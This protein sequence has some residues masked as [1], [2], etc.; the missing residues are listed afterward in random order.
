M[1]D[2]QDFAE[3]ELS[4]LRFLRRKS[5][6]QSNQPATYMRT[7]LFLGLSA[8]L[9]PS[10]SQAQPFDI[11]T[12]DPASTGPWSEVGRTTLTVPKVPNGSIALDGA[13]SSQEY[14]GFN[15]ITVTPGVN[16]W[17][18][19]FPGDR[20]W[21]SPD[22]SSFTYWLAHDD[23]NF[24]VGVQVKDD[25][26]TSDDPNGSFWKDDAIEIVVD[27]LSDRLDNNTDSS[28]DPVG[29]HSYVNFAGKF[30]AWDDTAS[31]IS[32][33]SW[34]TAVNWTYGTNGEVFG[35]GK[36][37]AGGWQLEVRL[38]KTLF[39]DAT[40]GNKLKNGYRMGFNI[41]LDD[42]D[43][44][45]TGV[46][47]DKSRTED[48][49]IQYF[50]ANRQRRIGYN[51]DY[52]AGLSAE[53]KA[54]KVWLLDPAADSRG[55]PL[56]VDSPGR[57]SHAGSGEIFFGYDKEVSASGQN[58][59]FVTSN[60]DS[61]LNA[62]PALIA[63]L[64]A[65]G[66]T[67]TPLTPPATAEEFRAAAVGKQLVILSETI[68]SGTVLDP[69]NDALGAFSLKDTDVP[70]ISFEAYMFD[71]A[72]W[73]KKAADGSNDWINWGNTGRSELAAEVQDARD[74]LYITKPGHPIAGGLTGKVKVYEVPYSFNFGVPSADADIIA[75]V[76]ADGSYPTLWVYEKGDKLFDGSVVPNKRIGLFLGQT[77]NP[78][79]NWPTDFADLTEAGRTLLL[80][81]IAYALGT[82]TPS[83]GS[84]DLSATRA[85]GKIRLA[86]TDTAAKLESASGVLGPWTAVANAASPFEQDIAGSQQQFF[87]LKK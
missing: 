50:W 40:A 55:L 70:I 77:A 28:K 45:G 83:T 79:A 21:D 4:C 75:S 39:Q 82:G 30:S 41:G 8:I 44:H 25:V 11:S 63:W 68:G 47:G 32:G 69:V 19:D 61:P 1:C 16:A 53:D 7:L 13:A 56:A 42:D 73:V 26:V 9:V 46:S 74:S 87:R 81:T 20:S 3:G 18:L 6:K 14:G 5:Y 76:Q 22:D 85:A 23:D 67:V 49:E 24:Y 78:N 51:A 29:G 48:L 62:D 38:K 36:A 43:K 17:I 2:H 54:A 86:W 64:R 35:V 27:A 66:Y 57:L 84:L 37:A 72:E 12:F 59:L 71:N 52:L 15:G 10:F 80:N 31:Q 34:A 60:A 33:T 65:K 58:I